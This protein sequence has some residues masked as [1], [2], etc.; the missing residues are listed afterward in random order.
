MKKHISIY[1]K[2][3]NYNLGDA[4]EYVPSE[5]SLSK[6]QDLHHLVN[7]EDRIENLMALTRE[8]HIKHGEIKADMCFLLK[9]HR[10]FLLHK[11][12]PFNN[13][14]FE[15]YINQYSIYEV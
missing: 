6:S 3:M 15:K 10:I 7:R 2:A 12:V 5:L 4:S 11:K 13:E 14:W 1:Y 9:I 8:E